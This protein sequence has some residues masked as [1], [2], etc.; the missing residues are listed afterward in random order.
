M[1]DFTNTQLGTSATNLI[2]SAVVSP[3]YVIATN[4]LS[5]LEAIMQTSSI[6]GKSIG[7]FEAVKEVVIDSKKF[8]MRGV[9]RCQGLGMAKAI[10]S[11]SMFHEGRMYLINY[12]KNSNAKHDISNNE[13]PKK[14]KIYIIHL[15]FYYY[16]RTS[17]E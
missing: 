3:I 1:K 6:K 13:F 9:F 15:D 5:R 10:I 16:I 7:V 14:N 17:I 4:P 2:A 12:F 11:L 8:G